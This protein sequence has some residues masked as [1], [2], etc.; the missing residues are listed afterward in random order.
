MKIAD[1]VFAIAMEHMK[2]VE[3][4]FKEW[5]DKVDYEMMEVMMR[6]NRLKEII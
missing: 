3:E 2:R 5:E 6:R 1:S 4:F